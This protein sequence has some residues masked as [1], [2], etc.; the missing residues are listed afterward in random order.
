VLQRNRSTTDHAFCICPI[1][2]KK[3]KNTDAVH[4]LLIDF[5]KKACDS[6]RRKVFYNTLVEFGI[7]MKLV[8]IRKMCLNETYCIVRV[9]KHLS[10]MFPIK[11]G[12]KE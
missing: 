11:N 3:W 8:R 7:C 1:L 9:S 12:L 2:E 5:K 10:D 6:I 4:Q